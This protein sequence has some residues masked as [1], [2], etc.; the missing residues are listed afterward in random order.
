M[1]CA[2]V[3]QACSKMHTWQTCAGPSD[4]EKKKRVYA[5]V[6]LARS[7]NDRKAETSAERRNG[8]TFM[9]V[10]LCCLAKN[11]LRSNLKKKNFFE[12]GAWPQTPLAVV[13][14]CTHCQPDHT[15][16]TFFNILNYPSVFAQGMHK[17]SQPTMHTA[18]KHPW[19]FL[20]ISFKHGWCTCSGSDTS[21]YFLLT[22]SWLP[23]D[24]STSSNHA[25]W[26]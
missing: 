13:C 6:W 26:Q 21:Q 5:R 23:L 2:V 11:G 25:Q 19:L 4:L 12:G 14:L 8:M 16:S 10:K 7:A 17:C 9:H 18:S 24:L 22:H 15:K 3:Q 20:C 1:G